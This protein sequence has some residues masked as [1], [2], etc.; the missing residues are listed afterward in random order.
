MLVVVALRA[1][2]RHA[3]QR[4]GHDLDGVCH[5]RVARDLLLDARVRRAVGSHAEKAGGGELVHV[6]GGKILVRQLHQLVA[7]EL[8]DDELVERLVRVERA[9]DVVAILPSPLALGVRIRVAI[10]VRVARDVEP[11]PPPTLAVMWRREQAVEQL[12]VGVGRS[13][14]LEGLDLR[15]RRRQAQEVKARAADER[16]A[17]G[18]RGE[19]E[20]GTGEFLAD[21][22]VNRRVISN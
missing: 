13:V 9:D 2:D 1:T 12:L 19:R 16:G 18:G 14:L 5:H 11:V 15:R 17:V 3:E 20:F 21:E 4:A 8:L 22:G 10:G 6:G 7:R